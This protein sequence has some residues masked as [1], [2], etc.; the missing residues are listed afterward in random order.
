MTTAE[1]IPN[2]ASPWA[3]K[4]W[5]AVAPFA[6]KDRYDKD[7]KDDDDKDDKDYGKDDKDDDD[8]KDSYRKSDK[9]DDDDGAAEGRL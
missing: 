4:H 6:G 5:N 3:A 7:D 9:E 2:Q 8:D 1:V